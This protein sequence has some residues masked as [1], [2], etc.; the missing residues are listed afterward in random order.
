MLKNPLNEEHQTGSGFIVSPMIKF[1]VPGVELTCM[2][3]L[4]LHTCK[5]VTT[6]E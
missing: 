6:N 5:L 4:D 3:L 1:S 2:T